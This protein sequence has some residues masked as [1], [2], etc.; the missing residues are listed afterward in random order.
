M[1]LNGVSVRATYSKV[2]NWAFSE[3]RLFFNASTLVPNYIVSIMDFKNSE[4]NSENGI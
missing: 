4:K 3:I 1:G 2:K